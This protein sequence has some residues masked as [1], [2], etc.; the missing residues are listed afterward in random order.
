V[1][2]SFEYQGQISAEQVAT[3]DNYLT[4]RFFGPG[5]LATPEPRTDQLP[6]AWSIVNFPG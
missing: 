6:M 5:R 2:D 3:A 1:I 4:G